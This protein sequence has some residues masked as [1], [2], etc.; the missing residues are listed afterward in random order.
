MIPIPAMFPELE[1]PDG[2]KREL[3]GPR[4]LLEPPEPVGRIAVSPAVPRPDWLDPKLL[5]ERTLVEEL[6][7]FDKLKKTPIVELRSKHGLVGAHSD[8]A[9]LDAAGNVV[10]WRSYVAYRDGS[11]LYLLVLQ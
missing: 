8:V 2:W 6:R 7:T 4:L 9:A 1:V 5:I 10:E 3:S 11:L